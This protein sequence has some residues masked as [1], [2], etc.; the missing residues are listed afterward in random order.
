MIV[1]LGTGAWGTAIKIVGVDG[2]SVDIQ[3]SI[4]GTGTPDT[5]GNPGI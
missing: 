2:T 3:Y 5:S 4:T 1:K